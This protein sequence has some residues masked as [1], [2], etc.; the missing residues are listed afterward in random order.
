MEERYKIDALMSASYL[1][2]SFYNA[3]YKNNN[4]NANLNGL[5]GGKKL[6]FQ[7]GEDYSNFGID[8]PMDGSKL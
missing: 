7:E 1:E 6:R 8:D 4:A 3:F 5:L 2:S